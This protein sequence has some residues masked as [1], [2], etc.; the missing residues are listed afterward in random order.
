VYAAAAVVLIS[1][2]SVAEKQKAAVTPPKTTI[3]VR[4]PVRQTGEVAGA[5]DTFTDT[6]RAVDNALNPTS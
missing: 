3:P 1:E 2:L 5:R 4:P 6:M